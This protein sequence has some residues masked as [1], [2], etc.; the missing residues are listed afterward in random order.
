MAATKTGRK[1]NVQVLGEKDA[2]QWHNDHK[3]LPADQ[4]SF[5]QSWASMHKSFE[6]GECDYVDPLLE[7]VLNRKPKGIEEVQDEL[8]KDDLRAD[9]KDF[10]GI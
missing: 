9:T 2:I 4:E 3:S 8:F 5:L 6:I 10:V 1:F 7:H